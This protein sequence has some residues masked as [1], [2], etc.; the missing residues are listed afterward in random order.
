[1]AARPASGRL[2][3]K[4]IFDRTNVEIQSG[5][6]RITLKNAA[7]GSLFALFGAVVLIWSLGPLLS[8]QYEEIKS[9]SWNVPSLAKEA[10]TYAFTLWMAGG[11]IRPGIS[12]GASDE[13]GHNVAEKPVHVH[14]FQAT[15]LHLLGIDHQRLTY[16]FQGRDFR[17]T[18]VH[19]R[20][21]RDLV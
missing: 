13:F 5:N 3:C 20:V 19:G 2:L 7:P 16:R 14:D 6:H 1:L 10:K 15:V 8:W 18:D 9:P 11:G 17:L 21:V 12:Y 4:G